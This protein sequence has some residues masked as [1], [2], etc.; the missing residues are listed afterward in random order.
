MGKIG[1]F[2]KMA[3]LSTAMKLISDD[4]LKY[5]KVYNGKIIL[6]VDYLSYDVYK[7]LGD[8]I[9]TQEAKDAIK[10]LDETFTN[11]E[12]IEKKYEE[13]VEETQLMA[14]KYRDAIASATNIEDLSAEE[15]YIK[16]TTSTPYLGDWAEPSNF[17]LET[18]NG[19]LIEFSH[20]L[21][22]ATLPYF[23]LSHQTKKKSRGGYWGLKGGPDLDKGSDLYIDGMVALNKF[24]KNKPRLLK[25]IKVE[26]L[27]KLKVY[28]KPFFNPDSREKFY[29]DELEVRREDLEYL[30]PSDIDIIEGDVSRSL[31]YIMM[32][33]NIINRKGELVQEIGIKV[34]KLL[35]LTRNKEYLDLSSKRDKINNILKNK[36]KF[37]NDYDKF[38]DL[39]DDSEVLAP[40]PGWFVNA[41]SVESNG[42]YLD[43]ITGL[44]ASKEKF[45]VVMNAQQQYDLLHDMPFKT[46]KF[47]I[48]ADTKDLNSLLTDKI[49]FVSSPNLSND[50]FLLNQKEKNK[51]IG[52]ANIKAM[53]V[54]IDAI[55]QKQ[56]T[57]PH[58]YA[59]HYIAWN[60]NTPIVQEAIK[61]WGSE[62][63]LV[64]AIGE[65]V[66]KQ[67]GEAYNWWRKFVKWMLKQLS[68]L[69]KLDKEQL[70]KIL[71]DALLTRQDLLQRSNLG[72]EQSRAML[73]E[74]AKRAGQEYDDNYL[75][76]EE[77]KELTQ[78]SD[79][80]NILEDL[81][82]LNFN[83]DVIYYLY[84]ISSKKLD[85][86]TYGKELKKLAVN[87]MAHGYNNQDILDSIKCL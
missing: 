62:E 46:P 45:F 64:Q 29:K 17:M 77:Q 85:L 4:P 28:S 26:V 22:S 81:D 43:E 56:D 63:A 86:H 57:L 58:E 73:Q 13:Y 44:W 41:V 60:R 83:D 10:E 15:L 32:A 49:T 42:Q 3:F 71:T 2:D 7:E 47:Q 66:V 72:I 59:H 27:D 8:Q 87:L 75:F 30:M 61:K 78:A 9:L 37:N 5:L 76:D 38:E 1:S 53:T 21:K 79:E 70:S 55:N 16:F 68:S 20:H 23:T 84:N 6:K 34:D 14:D 65:Q 74:D 67:K 18:E 35:S 80:G 82:D 25:A 24:K 36:E 50:I 12:G 33:N 40:M 69:S 11:T 19:D 31:D 48:L 51:I 39:D 54:L 52:Q